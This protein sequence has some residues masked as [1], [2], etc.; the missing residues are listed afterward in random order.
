[1]ERSKAVLESAVLLSG[2]GV[3]FDALSI[4]RRSKELVDR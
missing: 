1:M 2:L 3:A 4:N